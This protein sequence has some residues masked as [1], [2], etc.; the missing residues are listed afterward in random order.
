MV[1]D[2][3][4]GFFDENN[5]KCASSMKMMKSATFHPNICHKV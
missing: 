2:S 4:N 1:L 5:G 3:R